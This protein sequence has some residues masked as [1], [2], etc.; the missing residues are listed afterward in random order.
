MLML[1]LIVYPGALSSYGVVLIVP[2]LVLWRHRE[3][4]AGGG[5]TVAAIIAVAVDLQGGQRGFVANLLVWGACA[6]LLVADRARN[7]GVVPAGSA[8]AG[9]AAAAG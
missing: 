3:K 4:F 7:A 8:A 2:L 9:P 5:A 1:G 6:F